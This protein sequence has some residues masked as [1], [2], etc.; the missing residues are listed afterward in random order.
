[1]SLENIR[2][3]NKAHLDKKSFI[4]QAMESFNK[5]LEENPPDYALHIS[6]LMSMKA[7]FK[8]QVEA[9]YFVHLSTK[10]EKKFWVNSKIT[11]GQCVYNVD[12]LV[13]EIIK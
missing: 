6:Q 11:N 2:K 10:E 7:C 13:Q 3:D 5:F 8:D 4:L 1:M 12:I 9:E